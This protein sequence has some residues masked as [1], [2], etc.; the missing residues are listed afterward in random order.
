MK[1][2]GKL[3][4]VLCYDLAMWDSGVEGRFKR[5][6][7]YVCL[8]LIHVVVWQKTA[9]HYKAIILQIK[10]NLKKKQQQLYMYIYFLNY[11]IFFNVATKQWIITHITCIIILFKAAVLVNQQLEPQM[12]LLTYVFSLQH[13]EMFLYLYKI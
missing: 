3:S 1:Y 6:G 8:W 4:L 2:T 5:E 12:N 13:E 7:I 9:Q 10:I 11:L